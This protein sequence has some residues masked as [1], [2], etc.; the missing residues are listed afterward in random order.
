MHAHF[1]CFAIAWQRLHEI[2]TVVNSTQFL[3]CICRAG[4]GCFSSFVFSHFKF[5][6]FTYPIKFDFGNI[7]GLWEMLLL[8]QICFVE[9]KN[10]E[11][12]KL[13]ATRLKEKLLFTKI[14]FF[15]S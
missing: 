14:V 12:H 8:I 11:G 10:L 6:K 5:R 9:K 3:L 1:V 7:Y 2:Y 13:K 15:D 4:G